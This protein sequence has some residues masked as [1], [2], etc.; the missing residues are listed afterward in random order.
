MTADIVMH[1]F[2]RNPGGTPEWL[3][4]VILAVFIAVVLCLTLVYLLSYVHLSGI[5]PNAISLLTTL[6]I[7]SLE[8]V[9]NGIT[10]RWAVQ[11]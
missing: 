11:C 10:I 2:C 5:N 4:N 6:L 9:T 3:G 8:F 1:L 7:F